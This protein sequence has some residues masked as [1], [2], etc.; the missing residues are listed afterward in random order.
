MDFLK[1]Y[2]FADYT[3]D[4]SDNGYSY[5]DG[6]NWSVC[7]CTG[8]FVCSTTLRGCPGLDYSSTKGL[9]EY[10]KSTCCSQVNN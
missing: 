8:N 9:D 4:S 7:Y 2:L 5:Y 10:A 6:C 1:K 3:C